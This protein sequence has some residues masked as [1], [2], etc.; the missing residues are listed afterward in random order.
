MTDT[1]AEQPTA[2]AEHEHIFDARWYPL[3]RMH[4]RRVCVLP[5]CHHVQT[6][7]AKA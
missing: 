7:E 4:V 1:T 3:D 5:G 6:K 2:A